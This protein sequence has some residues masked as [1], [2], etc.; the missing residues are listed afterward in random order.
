MTIYAFQ[1]ENSTYEIDDGCDVG[2]TDPIVQVRRLSGVREPTPRQGTDGEWKTL[3]VPIDPSTIQIGDCIVF[4][5]RFEG[6]VAKSTI[7][8]P[9][10][11]IA[12]PGQ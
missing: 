8:S 5:W 4:V 2:V 9:V 3:A 11:A 1:T 12:E 10:T 6:N 7:T